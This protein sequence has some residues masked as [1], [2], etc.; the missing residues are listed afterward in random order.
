VLSIL[1]LLAA[2]AITPDAIPI[3]EGGICTSFSWIRLVPEESVSV[4]EGPDFNVFWFN[5]SG[6]KTDRPWAVYDG[7]GSLVK[8]SGPILLR[9]DGITI[10]R[11]V[12]S[13]KFVGYLAEKGG[14][15]H[16]FFGSLFDGSDKDLALFDRVD[17]SSEG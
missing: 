13:G 2:Q 7:N 12:E 10:Q 9:H 14:W 17:F 3:H 1:F 16:H 4:E 8:G 11:A 6:G 15:R 5:G